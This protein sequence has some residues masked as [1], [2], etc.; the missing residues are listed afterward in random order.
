MSAKC[1]MWLS[2][3]QGTKFWIWISFEPK[4]FSEPP[5]TEEK[6][7][8]LIGRIYTED[9]LGVRGETL[10]LNQINNS[11]N[12]FDEYNNNQHWY[13]ETSNSLNQNNLIKSKHIIYFSGLILPCPAK[14][15]S[16]VAEDRSN[17]VRTVLVESDDD[18]GCKIYWLSL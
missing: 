2:E 14:D 3:F 13:R 10:L 6:K 16:C 4:P 5:E 17:V 7:M 8:C 11:I 15:T 12:N 18:C 9:W 1:E